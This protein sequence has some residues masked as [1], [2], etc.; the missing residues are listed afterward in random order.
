MDIAANDEADDGVNYT[1][2]DAVDHTAN[3]KKKQRRAILVV[4]SFPC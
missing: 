2:D 3:G 4:G 1:S